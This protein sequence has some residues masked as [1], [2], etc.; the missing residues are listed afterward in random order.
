MDP[1]TVLN[2]LR[3]AIYDWQHAVINRDAD[4]QREALVRA[5]TCADA[6]DG[7]MT[8]GGHP[9]AAWST[10]RRLNFQDL[11]PRDAPPS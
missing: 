4:A 7:W 10:E 3:Q 2:Q 8:R 1:D 5:T 6:L 9:P 11:E